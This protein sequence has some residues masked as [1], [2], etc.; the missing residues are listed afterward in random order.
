MRLFI[1]LLFVCVGAGEAA[2][3]D[4]RGLAPLRSTRTDVERLLGTPPVGRNND[5]A[6]V[7]H[8]ENEDVLVRYSTGRCI[9]KWD[10]PRDTILYIQVFP[11]NK[12]K[13]SE[14]RLDIS[15]YKKIPDPELPDYSY[16]DNEEEGF[17][18]NVHTVQGLVHIFIYYPPAKD[19][20]LR[21][22]VPVMPNK[23]LQPTPR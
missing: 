9:E 3:R 17:E 16:Y 12:P 14:L 1:C 15:K 4:W 23:R 21:C 19:D 2:A 20:K 22:S 5:D 10:V 7:Y 13:F 18:L 6:V 8:T 11:K